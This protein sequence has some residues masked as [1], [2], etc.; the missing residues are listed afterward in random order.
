MISPAAPF[1]LPAVAQSGRGERTWNDCDRDLR[2]QRNDSRP[3][4]RS[5][6]VRPLKQPSFLIL[7]RGR[8]SK[9][10]PIL[11]RVPIWIRRT[12]LEATWRR[13][14][15]GFSDEPER[16]RSS[17]EVRSCAGF[18]VPLVTEPGSHPPR[19]DT[20]EK[21]LSGLK[22]AALDERRFSL[23]FQISSA[24][25]TVPASGTVPAS[26]AAVGGPGGSGVPARTMRGGGVGTVAPV[27][28][29]AGSAVAGTGRL[30]TTVAAVA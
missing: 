30:V 9:L 14:S 15:G 7:P 6:K 19:I 25:S 17:A 21:R 22:N 27:S 29:I 18:Q 3:A 12:C 4:P 26:S 2:F 20:Y 16:Y 1:S 10:W 24:M 28:G 13:F 8:P 11:I 5:D 23:S